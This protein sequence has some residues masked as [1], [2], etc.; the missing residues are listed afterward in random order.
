MPDRYTLEL[1]T[2]FASNTGGPYTHAWDRVIVPA[3]G[4][5]RGVWAGAVSLASNA[6]VNTVD[7]YRQADAPA[8][9]SNTATTILTAPISLVNNRDVASGIPSEPGS[10]LNAG[11]TLELRTYSGTTA[12]TPSFITLGATVEIER[13]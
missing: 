3:T 7:I 1:R 12:A 11:D 4:V 8:A 2:A 9:G 6:Y 13:T 5:V 10:L